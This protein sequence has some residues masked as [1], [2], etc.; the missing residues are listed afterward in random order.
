MRLSPEQQH[1]IRALTAEHIGDDAR[2]WLLG[3]RAAGVPPGPTR[4]IRV[5]VRVASVA[6]L[7]TPRGREVPRTAS[8]AIGRK[9]VPSP[10]SKGEPATVA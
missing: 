5:P 10:T 2:I 6:G 7:L 9:A 4:A 8:I 3:S 1:A